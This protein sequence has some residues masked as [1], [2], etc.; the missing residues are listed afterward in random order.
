MMLLSLKSKTAVNGSAS[1]QHMSILFE[2]DSDTAGGFLLLQCKCFGNSRQR[3]SP[4]H[5]GLMAYPMQHA[6]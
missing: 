4:Q 6:G 5:A 3:T 1:H 2:Q